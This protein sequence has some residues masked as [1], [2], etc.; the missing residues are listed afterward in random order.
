MTEYRPNGRSHKM[1]MSLSRRRAK[2]GWL[3]GDI[4]LQ[5]YAPRSAL[6]GPRYAI[7][8]MEMDGLIHKSGEMW[9]ITPIGLMTL[10][11]LNKEV[12]MCP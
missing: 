3:L 12:S 6:K 9:E 8:R 7:R 4:G 2:T 10:N 11:G 1:L 5:G